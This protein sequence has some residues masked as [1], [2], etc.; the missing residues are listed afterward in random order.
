MSGDGQCPIGGAVTAPLP[1]PP[2]H[3]CIVRHLTIYY[4]DCSAPWVGD[5][6]VM[7]VVVTLEEAKKVMWRRFNCIAPVMTADPI[8]DWYL[9][10]M[11]TRGGR[12][13]LPI[14]APADM[15]LPWWCRIIVDV[16][17][18]RNSCLFANCVDWWLVLVVPTYLPPLF[19]CVAYVR[20]CY[21]VRCMAC[22]GIFLLF[23]ALNWFVTRI[24]DK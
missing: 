8:V 12:Y 6:M 15:I 5:V 1:C 17:W 3:F 10:M 11:V 18:R 9:L 4:Y 24:I 7:S 21:C 13:C 14:A 2:S 16:P 19:R 22:I 23:C 20:Y